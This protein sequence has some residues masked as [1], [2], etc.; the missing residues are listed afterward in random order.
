MHINININKNKTKKSAGYTLLELLIVIG[1]IGLTVGV[2]GDIIL[3]LVRSYTKTQAT[4]E[5]ERTSN[6]AVSKIE[7]EFKNAVSNV[8]FGTSTDSV[9]FY[10]K[11]YNNSTLYPVSYRYTP[12]CPSTDTGNTGCIQRCD[13]LEA[14]CT[15]AGDWKPITDTDS[16]IVA[17]NGGKV[18]SKASRDGTTPIALSINMKL[19]KNINGSINNPFSGELVVKTTVVAKG[20]Y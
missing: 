14:S 8:T 7:K 5:L 3:S 20:T 9:S 10:T 19:T 6:Y 13:K 18:F 2:T 4:N 11:Y 17:T 12:G 15:V 1:L 16:V